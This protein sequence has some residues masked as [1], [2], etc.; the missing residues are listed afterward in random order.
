[1]NERTVK[2]IIVFRKD[3]LKGENA[4]RK[5]KFGSQ[6][7]HASLG[8]VISMMDKK[9]MLDDKDILV[10][11]NFSLNFELDS[12]LDKWLNGIFTKICLGV[13]N[14]EELVALYDRIKEEK[15]EIPCVMIEDNG[16]TEFHG[17]K[18]KTCIGIGPFWGDEI[19]P[20]TN[21]LKLL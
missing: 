8:A 3:L 21:L 10:G 9:P 7:G 20:Y 18:T 15:P 12:I 17:V 11:Y 2:Q 6:V 5:G 14:E 13:D 19:D 1:M 16:L 4:I